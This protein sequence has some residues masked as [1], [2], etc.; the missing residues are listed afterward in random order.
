[1]L[2][3]SAGLGHIAACSGWHHAQY[4]VHLPKQASSVVP[5]NHIHDWGALDDHGHVDYS[6]VQVH[7]DAVP[8]SSAG[9]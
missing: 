9:L 3:L 6:T 5:S 4:A 8:S 7:T 2:S 1:M